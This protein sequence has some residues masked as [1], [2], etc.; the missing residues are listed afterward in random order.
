MSDKVSDEKMNVRYELFKDY[1][2]ENN[3]NICNIE[4]MKFI[5]EMSAEYERIHNRPCLS[6]QD[7]FDNFIK[8]KVLSQIAENTARRDI[9]IGVLQ[10]SSFMNKLLEKYNIS[11]ETKKEDQGLLKRIEFSWERGQ[12]EKV[13]KQYDEMLEKLPEEYKSKYYDYLKFKGEDGALQNSREF[14]YKKDILENIE[15]IEKIDSKVKIFIYWTDENGMKSFMENTAYSLE[16]ANSLVPKSLEHLKHARENLQMP[17]I[18][19]DIK[20]SIIIDD[21]NNFQISK[22][23]D[24]LL[25]CEEPKDFYE[26]IEKHYGLDMLN[27]IREIEKS[28]NTC[29]EEEEEETL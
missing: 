18:S 25:G 16:R 24:F 17:Y 8:Y 13:A 10:S 3:I 21:G 14:S 6:N 27:E 7:E 9:G 22:P 29:N 12:I 11:E 15:K 23:D 2:K 4:Y 20:F 28:T 5:D 19:N 1:A 26:V